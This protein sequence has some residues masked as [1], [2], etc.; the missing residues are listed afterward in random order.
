MHKLILFGSLGLNAA[1]AIFTIGQQGNK[2]ATSSENTTQESALMESVAGEHAQAEDAQTTLL[3]KLLEESPEELGKSIGALGLDKQQAGF[4]IHTILRSRQFLTET[5]PRQAERAWWQGARYYGR[6]S[7]GCIDGDIEDVS[8]QTNRAL[9]A[10]GISAETPCY[11]AGTNYRCLPEERRRIL[12]NINKDYEAMM[13]ELHKKAGNFWLPQDEAASD[14]LREQREADL[15]AA[16]SPEERTLVQKANST[17]TREILGA[18]GNLIEDEGTFNQLYALYEDAVQKH[19]EDLFSNW[20]WNKKSIEERRAMQTTLTALEAQSQS[21]FTLESLQN[22]QHS[23]DEDVSLCARAAKRL[24]LD[25]KR[26]ESEILSLRQ[27]V[28]ASSQQLSQEPHQT[29]ENLQEDLKALADTSRERL[30]QILGAE[31]AQAYSERTSWLDLLDQGRAIRPTK[32]G[33]WERLGD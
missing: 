3:R 14:L 9:E 16:L 8:E 27:A 23:R 25:P 7:G 12:A 4:L 32:L 18:Y 26:L 10:A 28:A 19:G 17:I 6:R 11:I 24:D 15:E 21:L 31:G 22:Q 2:P 29:P 13:R 1:A 30:A 33:G 20:A 5:P